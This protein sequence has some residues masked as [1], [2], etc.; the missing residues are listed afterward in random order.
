MRIYTKTGDQGETALF[1]GNRV[2]KDDSFVHALGTVD[3]LSAA[4]GLSIAFLPTD[5]AFSIYKEQL[6]EIQ[7]TLFD[8]GAAVATPRTKASEDKIGKTRFDAEG[9][10]QLEEWMDQMSKELPPLRQFILPGG[11][12]AAAH[13]HMARNICRRA[14]RHAVPLFRHGAVSEKVIVYL[15]RLSDY[16]FVLTRRVNQLTHAVETPWKQHSH[17][18]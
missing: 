7:H 10:K 12:T 4:L 8:L 17:T 11:H 13:L 18:S 6:E 16:L 1:S 9:T 5:E 14:E 2:P 15:N 3:E